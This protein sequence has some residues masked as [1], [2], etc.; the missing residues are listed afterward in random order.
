[1]PAREVPAGGGC[2]G[3]VPSQ[4]AMMRWPLQ[5][6]HASLGLGCVASSTPQPG[7]G[8]G[9]ASGRPACHRPELLLPGERARTRLVQ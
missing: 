5:V 2:P 8:G 6:G 9:V 7:T 3:Q 4:D 1:M